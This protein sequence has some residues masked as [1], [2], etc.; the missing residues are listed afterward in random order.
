MRGDNTKDFQ[1]PVHETIN[2]KI[3]FKTLI[4]AKS[5][6]YQKYADG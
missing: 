2:M 5:Y 6:Q 1:L 4:N 3:Y